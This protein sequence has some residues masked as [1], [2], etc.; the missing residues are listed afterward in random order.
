MT[1]TAAHPSPQHLRALARA[2]QVRLARA[3][4]KRRI[5]DSRLSAGE[6]FLECPWEA[7]SMSVADV[8]MSQRRWGGTRCRKFLF[9]LHISETRTVGGLTQRQ[10]AALADRLAGGVGASTP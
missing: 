5:A 6:V 8:L 1:A 7:A 10:R 2:N 9:G 3:D 4:L